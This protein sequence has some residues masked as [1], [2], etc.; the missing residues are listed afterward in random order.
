[1]HVGPG[2]PLGAAVRGAETH[3]RADVAGA[4]S[5]EAGA[6]RVRCGAKVDAGDRDGGG[7]VRGVALKAQRG[8]H[9]LEGRSVRRVAG[10]DDDQ[11]GGPAARGGG[12]MKGYPRSGAAVTT[13]GEGWQACGALAGF[14][15]QGRARGGACGEAGGQKL[16]RGEGGQGGKRGGRG[17]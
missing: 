6:A 14:L 12:F 2:D 13:S 7:D 5:H 16:D 15:L 3:E 4:V 10:D 17:D 11:E 9:R 8:R 1:M